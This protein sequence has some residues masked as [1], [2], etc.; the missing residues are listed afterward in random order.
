MSYFI[1]NLPTDIVSNIKEFV[2][3]VDIR[4]ELIYSKYK[5]N[6]ESLKEI[7]KSFNSK[8]LADINWKYLYY[9]IYKTSPPGFDSNNNLTPIFDCIPEE[10]Y[11]R[12]TLPIHQ[13][14]SMN[15]VCQRNTGNY[16]IHAFVTRSD[17]NM[18]HRTETGRKRQQ[19]ANIMDAWHWIKRGRFSSK[20]QKFDWYMC[21]VEF[22]LVR[23]LLL[24]RP[25]AAKIKKMQAKM[26]R[27]QQKM[28]KIN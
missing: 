1:S 6:Y 3:S 14:T 25:Y 21:N 2:L 15:K 24:L 23:A 5:I 8:Q 22:E 11:M 20:I 9:K 17:A 28:Q 12:S 18:D 10:Y 4:L 19:N 13:R 7:L 27:M 26:K 16:G